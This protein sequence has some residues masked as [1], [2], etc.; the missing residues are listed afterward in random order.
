MSFLYNIQVQVDDTVH[1]VGGF[2]TAH[3]AT[4]S[5]HIEASHFGG[6][7]RPQTGLQEAIEAGEK[8]IEVR[9][10]APRITVIVS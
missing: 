5:A 4:I 9:A 1:E 7:N 10:A 3:A 8:S 6:L 2:D